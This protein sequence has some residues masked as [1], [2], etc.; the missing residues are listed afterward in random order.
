MGRD[1]GRDYRDTAVRD[2][3]VLQPGAVAGSRGEAAAAGTA[4]SAPAA[5]ALLGGLW[6]VISR[7]VF[8]F[9]GMALGPRGLVNGVVIGAAIALIATVRMATSTSSPML[10]AATMV[11]GGWMIA[12]PWVYGYAH[13]GAGSRPVWSDVVTGAVIALVSLASWSAG[14]AARRV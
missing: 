13:W 10:S 4:A 14:M 5:L 2:E 6:L 3:S 12:S 1:T 11:L 9:S 8:N 7:L